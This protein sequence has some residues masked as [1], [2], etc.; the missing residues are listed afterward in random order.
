MPSAASHHEHRPVRVVQESLGGASEDSRGDAGSAAGSGHDDG[1][2]ELVR[3]AHDALPC[4][5]FVLDR[6]RAR[7]QSCVLRQFRTLGRELLGLIAGRCVELSAPATATV[8]GAPS[9][10]AGALQSIDVQTQIT[11]AEPGLSRLPAR[12]V[13]AR[14]GAEPS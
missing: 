3:T 1:R 12:S 14:A 2:V 5:A 4:G 11:T 9:S 10:A 13:A 8:A 6:P 7:L